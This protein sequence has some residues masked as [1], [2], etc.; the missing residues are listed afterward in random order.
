M[1]SQRPTTYI[2]EYLDPS[3]W[4]TL[5]EFLQSDAAALVQLQDALRK[6][7]ARLRSKEYV[8]RD[9]RTDHI[10]IRTN[11]PRESPELKVIDFDWARSV[12]RVRYPAARNP[13]IK[14]IKWPGKAGGLIQDGHDWEL[15]SYWLP[16][17]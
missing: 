17:E 9:L 6:I 11:S 5:Y 7:V 12:N 1:V 4:E 3:T 14:G 15:I 2:V 8:H 13:Q 10:M 16:P